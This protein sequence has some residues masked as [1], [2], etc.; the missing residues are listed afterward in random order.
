MDTIKWYIDGVEENTKRD[1]LE[2]SKSFLQGEYEIKMWCRFENDSTISKTGAL[3]I[4]SCNQSA[5]F[6]ANNVLHSELKDTTF[7]NK[8]VNFRAEISV[9]HPTD[10]E[11]I[12]WY[13]DSKD[14]NGFIEETSALNQAQ[15]SKPFENGSYEIKM[16]AKYDNGETATLTGTLKI[17]ALWIKI[18]NVRY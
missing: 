11:K 6:F 8:N 3:I 13:M 1:S 14:G 18:R 5:A 15:W 17:Q 2:W 12:K 16:V 7:C 10:P 4:K 9:L